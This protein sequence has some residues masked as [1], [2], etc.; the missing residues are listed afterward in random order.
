M[1]A[2]LSIDEIAGL[3]GVL[4]KTARDKIVT[5]PDFPAP[6]FRLSQRI[7]KWSRDE[8]LEYLTKKTHAGG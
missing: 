3:L 5:R 8:V 7:R 6:V 4:P 1:T 2:L